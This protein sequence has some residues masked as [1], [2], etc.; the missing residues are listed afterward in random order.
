MPKSL[1]SKPI[2]VELRGLG[3][4]VR[5]GDGFKDEIVVASAAALRFLKRRGGG[6]GAQNIK[7]RGVRGYLEIEVEEAVH[8]NADAF[9]SA[10]S[11][12]FIVDRKGSSCVFWYLFRPGVMIWGIT[13]AFGLNA[14][15]A[16]SKRKTAPCET[17]GKIVAPATGLA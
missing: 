8:K 13:L 12:P 7:E 15:V 3:F 2:P 4:G 16:E 17:G 11:A 1:K 14:I 10:R 9:L 5:S 6:Q